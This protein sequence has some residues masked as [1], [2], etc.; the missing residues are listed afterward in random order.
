[1]TA[2][3]LCLPFPLRPDFLAQL[4]VPLDMTKAEADRLSAFVAS[5]VVPSQAQAASGVDAGAAVAQP[6]DAAK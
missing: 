3:Y 1:M 5:L 2:T 6:S 4:V